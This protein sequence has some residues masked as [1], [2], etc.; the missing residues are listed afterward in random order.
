MCNFQA[1]SGLGHCEE[2]ERK[3]QKL[4]S[5]LGEKRKIQEEDLLQDFQL[6]NREKF[7][8]R[9]AAADLTLARSAC[10]R[11]DLEHVTMLDTK[12]HR[13]SK[14]ILSGQMRMN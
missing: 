4:K 14:K 7:I 2:V 6:R 10:Q 9:K 1:F 13:E 3:Q 12:N 5:R 8:Q 11:L